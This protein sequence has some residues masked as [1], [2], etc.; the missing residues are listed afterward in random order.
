[1]DVT[2]GAGAQ[3]ILNITGERVALGP[4]RRDLLP[5]YT[6]WFNDFSV[7]LPYLLNLGPRTLESRQAWYDRIA[8]GEPGRVDFTIYERLTLRAIGWTNLDAIDHAQRRA[9]YNICIGERDCWGK[10]YGT[11]TTI[12]MLDYGFTILGL[13]NIMLQ[14]DSYNE[15][16]IRCYRRAGYKE[17]GRRRE[18]RRVRDRV[19]DRVFMDC[20]SSE[21]RSPVL[22]ALLPAEGLGRAHTGETDRGS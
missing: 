12:L 3:P 22:H 9:Q 10:E 21:F 6:R 1:M 2:T 16:A 14:V 8:A 13:H 5:L 20:L 4:F 18:A 19:Y 7:T 15:R 17:I 11:E